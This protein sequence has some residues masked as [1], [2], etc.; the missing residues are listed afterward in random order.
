MY[1]IK[2]YPCVAKVRSKGGVHNENIWVDSTLKERNL[3][4]VV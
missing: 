3:W 2:G 4:F 1:E